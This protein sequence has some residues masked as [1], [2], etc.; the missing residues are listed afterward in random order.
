M[1][2]IADT[3]KNDPEVWVGKGLH[4][5]SAWGNEPD[6]NS[7]S[8][9][10]LQAGNGYALPLGVDLYT[11][12]SR[13]YIESIFFEVNN[14]IGLHQGALNLD[15]LG[16]LGIMKSPQQTSRPTIHMVFTVW[17]MLRSLRS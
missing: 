7:Q 15:P 3:F 6:L 9:C 2:L 17:Q 11:L 8:L 13:H 16:L 4:R 1:G 10:N 14:V 5:F 12:S